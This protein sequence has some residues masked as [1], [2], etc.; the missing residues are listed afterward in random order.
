VKKFQC[1]RCRKWCQVILATLCDHC[2][3]R[4]RD[5]DY[6]PRRSGRT[7]KNIMQLDDDPRKVMIFPNE[8]LAAHYRRIYSW[9]AHQIYGPHAIIHNRLRGHTC[10]SVLLDHMV[11]QS[12]SDPRFWFMYQQ[13]CT[14][15]DAKH[16][17]VMA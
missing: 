7:L 5:N 3:E 2:F 15:E 13:I 8:Q 11:A 17:H 10:D 6:F 14:H 1:E 4:A 9:L 16:S 12:M